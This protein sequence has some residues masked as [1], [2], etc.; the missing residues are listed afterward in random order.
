MALSPKERER[1]IE[2][3]R[4]RYETRHALHREYCARHRHSRWLWWLAAIVL[5]CLV[6]RHWRCGGM[7]Y[8]YYG[9]GAGMM[10]GERCWHHGDWQKGD[11]KEEGEKAQPEQALPPKK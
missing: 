8:P 10:A 6:Y 3:E 2:E 1:I 5:A 11:L 7:R 4:L 9:Q